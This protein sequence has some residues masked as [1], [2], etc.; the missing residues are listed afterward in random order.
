MDEQI[1][2]CKSWLIRRTI[3][4]F[5]RAAKYFGERIAK[6]MRFLIT[7]RVTEK[8]KKKKRKKKIGE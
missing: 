3:N 1:C 2:F 8:E 5:E 4:S 7:D 6:N